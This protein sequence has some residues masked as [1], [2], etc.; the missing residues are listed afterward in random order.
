MQMLVTGG[1]GFV[2]RY[3]VEQ[4]LARGDTVRVFARGHYPE[5]ATLGAS[6][7][8]GDLQDR[9]AI[10]AAC[11][12]VDV[13]FHVAAQPGLWGTWPDFYR[14]NVLGTQNVIAAC[15]SQH[16]PKLVFTSSPSVIFDNRAHEGA[17]ESLPYPA[18]YESL[19]AQT[20]AIAEGMI[21]AANS[22]DLLTVA[23]R[24][25][26]VWGPRD[27]HILPRLIARARA[28]R[29][30]Q[31]GE[32][33]NRVDISYVEDVARAHLLAAD[34]LEAGSPLAGQAY[35]ISQNDPINLWPWIRNFL[36]A[37]DIPPPRRRISLPAARAIGG[38]LEFLFRSLKLPG[39]P[40]L[41]RFLASE[42]ALSH[43]YDITRARRDFGFEPQFSMAEALDKTL[44]SLQTD[45]NTAQ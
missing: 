24:P 3:V 4:L 33:H 17:D 16:V 23:L 37:L 1:G 11:E 10:T 27:A 25:H 19:Y 20:K 45:K 12:G 28:G 18:R 41:T 38:S 6:L 40:P 30:I 43:Y 22:R 39:E 36:A 44:R 31:V 5:L 14:P 7:V 8:R 13:V 34:A 42:L 29:L 21:L 35:F 2:G 32:G 26:L 15:R 9:A